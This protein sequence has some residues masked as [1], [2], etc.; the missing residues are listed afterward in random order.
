M[1]D[2][3]RT[4]RAKR[5]P[6]SPPGTENSRTLTKKKKRSGVRH[7]V[8][9]DKGEGARKAGRNGAPENL[10]KPFLN[11]LGQRRKTDTQCRK[12]VAGKGR[13][14]SLLLQWSWRDFG[15]ESGQVVKKRGSLGVVQGWVQSEG[16]GSPNKRNRLSVRRGGT[17]RNKPLTAGQLFTRSITDRRGASNQKKKRVLKIRR[18]GW[19]KES[20]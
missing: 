4:P 12:M 7:S 13:Y 9:G 16:E 3:E 2:V 17:R 1:K 18:R 15:E 11:K 6:T 10:W 14:Q 5:S 8:R 19:K 20:G